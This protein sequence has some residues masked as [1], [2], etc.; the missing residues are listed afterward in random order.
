[1][2]EP[3]RVLFLCTG[4]SCRSQMAEGF[5]NALLGDQVQAMSCGIEKHG[6][7][8][9]AVRVMQEA[10]VDISGHHSK[11]LDEMDT[12]AVEVPS[13]A[14]IRKSISAGASRTS[15]HSKSP[16]APGACVARASAKAARGSRIPTKT[17]SP[18]AIS[19]A[20]ATII[21]SRLVYFIQ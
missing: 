16:T 4:N 13:C 17:T 19:R 21:I 8:A 11:T 9:D 12:S 3:T 1:M 2:T 6:M 5:S 10:G 14:V 20:A 15:P 18:S 7:N